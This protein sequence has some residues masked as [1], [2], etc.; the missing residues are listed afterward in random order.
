[1]SQDFD[2]WSATWPSSWEFIVVS[3]LVFFGYAS[4]FLPRWGIAALALLWGGFSIPNVGIG[5][6][7]LG[8]IFIF[9]A[10]AAGWWSRPMLVRVVEAVPVR[11][12]RPVLE[13]LA[14][15][16]DID[17]IEERFTHE[18]E[19]SLGES[20]HELRR[21]WDAG[22]HDRETLLR[23]LFLCWFS[24]RAGSELLGFP[25]GTETQP[26][27]MEAANFA[28]E[29]WTQDA[30]VQF[31]TGTLLQ[32]DPQWV[33]PPDRWAA[34]AIACLERA[35]ALQPRGFAAA[36]FRSRGAYGAFFRTQ[37][38]EDGWSLRL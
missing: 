32:A 21:R 16:P 37:L 33:F 13:S 8:E 25:P 20:L 27:F 19:P 14:Y 5:N 18:A 24:N 2:L 34:V 17:A 35:L 10:Y 6:T 30:E 22:L 12:P 7:L 9:A 36:D 26:L 11:R 28:I 1:M 4:A 23:L 31:V 38:A 29:R 3:R 15:I